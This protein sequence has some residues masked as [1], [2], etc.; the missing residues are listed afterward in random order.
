MALQTQITEELRNVFADTLDKCIS[1]SAIL[2]SYREGG[3]VRTVIELHMQFLE[4][5][6]KLDH[7][8]KIFLH[9]QATIII[10]KS[11]YPFLILQDTKGLNCQTFFKEN[12]AIGFKS[13]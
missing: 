5:H 12:L 7:T 4:T 13:Y 2:V 1:R 10:E 9:L 6:L 8:S 3:R 11:K